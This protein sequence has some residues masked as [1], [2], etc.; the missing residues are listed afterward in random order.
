MRNFPRILLND[1]LF[2]IDRDRLTCSGGI[3][4]LDLML[5]L[6]ESRLDSQVAQLIC[7]QFILD[8]VRNDRDRQYVPLRAQIGASHQTLIK[9]AAVD[10]GQHREALVAR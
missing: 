5:N 10:G 2:T 4:P 7:E 8:R 1:Q 6:V 3:A 9:V